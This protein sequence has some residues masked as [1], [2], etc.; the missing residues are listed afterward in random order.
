MDL[1]SPLLE[2]MQ[3]YASSKHKFPTHIYATPDAAKRLLY[4]F[5]GSLMLGMEL[6]I[7]SEM[8]ENANGKDFFLAA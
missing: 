2:E 3:V 6:I 8:P 4:K 1:I 7:V 5:G